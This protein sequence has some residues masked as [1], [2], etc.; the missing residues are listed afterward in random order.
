VSSTESSVAFD[1]AAE[2]YDATRGSS[3]EAE[4]ALTQLLRDELGGRGQVLEVGVGT[5]LVA[6]PLAAAGVS[7]VGLD[8]ARPMMDRLVEKA[9][10]GSPLPLIQGD[11]TKMPLRDGAV[12]GAYLRW[13]LHLI[14]DWRGALGEIVRVLRPPATLVV[15]LGSYGGPR[16]EIQER[17]T[18]LAGITLQPVGLMWDGYDELDAA[19]IALGALPRAL[20]SILETERESLA[21]FIDGIANNRYSWTWKLSDPTLLSSLADEVRAWAEARHGPIDEVQE[22]TYEISSRAYDLAG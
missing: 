14:P 3:P 19:M 8:L 16:S 10:G 15:M 20:P 22:G 13:V 1:R 17:F 18:E 21:T 2:Y 12:T 4:R 11:A 7:V 5:G 6:L 9:G